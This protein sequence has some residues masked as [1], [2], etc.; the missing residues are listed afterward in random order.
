[1]LPLLSPRLVGPTMARAA[2]FDE[3]V[4]RLGS[5]ESHIHGTGNIEWIGENGVRI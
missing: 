4:G 5:K 1:M 3:S 2:T